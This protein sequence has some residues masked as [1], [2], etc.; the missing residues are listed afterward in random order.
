MHAGIGAN[1]AWSGGST[2]HRSHQGRYPRKPDSSIPSPAKEVHSGVNAADLPQQQQQWAELLTARVEWQECSTAHQ[3]LQNKLMVLPTSSEEDFMPSISSEISSALGR[4]TEFRIP[5]MV[6][7][8]S[9]YEKANAVAEPLRRQRGV[10][11]N[12]NY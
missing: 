4:P 9:L 10:S 5:N 7:A 2:R 8:G 6:Q 1:Q 12:K 11:L 3:K